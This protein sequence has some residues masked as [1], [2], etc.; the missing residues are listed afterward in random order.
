MQSVVESQRMLAEAM[1]QMANRDGHHVRQGPKQ[2]QYST[3]KDFM[4]IKPPIF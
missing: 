2:N 4:D 1:R 3:F